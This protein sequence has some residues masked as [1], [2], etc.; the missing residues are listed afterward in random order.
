MAKNQAMA[1]AF[2]RLGK[3]NISAMGIIVYMNMRIVTYVSFLWIIL[4]IFVVIRNQTEPG[5]FILGFR[6]EE[7]V[8]HGDGGHFVFHLHCSAAV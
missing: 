2:Q 1:D 4:W 6:G 5:A 7:L 3:N 8:C